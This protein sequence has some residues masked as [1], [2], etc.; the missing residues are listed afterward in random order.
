MREIPTPISVEEALRDTSLSLDIP[1]GTELTVGPFEEQFFE[2]FHLVEVRSF[3]DLRQL[4]FIH[5]EISEEQMIRAIRADDLS[6]RES[7]ERVTSHSSSCS[8]EG[9]DYQRE[10]RISRRQFQNN[11]IELLQPLHRDLLKANDPA[12]IHPYHHSKAWLSRSSLYI[13]G[14]YSL[15]DI[16]IGDKAT[17]TMTPTVQAL[18][19]NDINIGRDG[20]LRFTSGG[21]HVKCKTLN[22]PSRFSDLKLV[23]K[24]V[25]G[26]SREIRRTVQ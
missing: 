17:L 7:L 9:Q 5:R 18:Y 23:E 15:F 11:L 24:Y 19:A 1:E 2:A 22:G 10:I 12:V 16:N 13:V 6:H 26:L 20:R 25:G 4:G 8:C 3:D 14:I 21:V